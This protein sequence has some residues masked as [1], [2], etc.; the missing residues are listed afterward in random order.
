MDTIVA[1]STAPGRSAIGVVRLSGPQ[2][3][4]IAKSIVGDQKLDLMAGA[5]RGRS[6][7][8]PGRGS[9]SK[10]A[11]RSGPSVRQGRPKIRDGNRRI[12]SN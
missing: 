7:R 8:P 12:R 11:E 4:A 2:V 10:V 3:L 1:L 5:V 9:M 6:G